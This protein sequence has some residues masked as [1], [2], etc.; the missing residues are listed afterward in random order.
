MTTT[1]E[2]ILGGEVR[3][4]AMRG[5]EKAE[6][7]NSRRGYSRKASQVNDHALQGHII[8]LGPI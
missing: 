5:G 7:G 3:S 8:R 4:R 6:D 1:R 2:E